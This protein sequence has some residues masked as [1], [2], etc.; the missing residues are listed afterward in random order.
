M[1]AIHNE[2]PYNDTYEC[3]RMRQALLL[4]QPEGGGFPAKGLFVE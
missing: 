4:T 2:D 3:V 1:W